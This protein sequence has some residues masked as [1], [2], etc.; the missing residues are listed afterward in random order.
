M[1]KQTFIGFVFAVLFS[2]SANMA[3]LAQTNGETIDINYKKIEQ[4]VDKNDAQ[5]E[6][7]MKRFIAGDTTLTKD[8]CAKIYYGSFFSSK[9]SYNDV[10]NEI[11]NAM[12]NENYSEALKL[13]E[14]ELAKSPASLGLLDKAAVCCQLLGKDPNVYV[15]RAMMILDVIFSS[16]DGY[17][18]ETALKVVAVADEYFIIYAV[19]GA[20]LKQQA[21]VHNCDV[22][23]IYSEEDPSQ[24][25]DL[26][27]DVSL[28]LSA[29]NAIFGIKDDGLKKGKEKKSRKK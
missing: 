20:E 8:E 5:F 12:K 27:F 7:L 26:Y 4:F 29:L 10:T 19:L 13:C 16:G 21:L 11:R 23:T 28:H 24:T 18:E 3:G 25:T 15:Q 22:M 6:A 9:Y 17:S 14:D 2:F 1:N